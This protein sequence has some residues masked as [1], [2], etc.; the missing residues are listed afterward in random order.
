MLVGNA[1]V[2][3]VKRLGKVR[4]AANAPGIVTCSRLS[5]GIVFF[6]PS[7]LHAPHPLRCGGLEVPL[8]SFALAPRIRGTFRLE[9]LRAPHPLR[10]GG[11][12]TQ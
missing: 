11:P 1:H 10:C 7:S 2:P 8:Y 3:P 9:T 4:A 6:M 12:E 5:P